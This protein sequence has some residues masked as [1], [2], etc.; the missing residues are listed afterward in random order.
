MNKAANLFILEVNLDEFSIGV[1]NKQPLSTV[2]P[3]QSAHSGVTG[4][5]DYISLNFCL[6]VTDVREQHSDSVPIRAAIG[7]SL[8]TRINLH[9]GHRIFTLLLNE[10]K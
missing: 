1:A 10:N 9:H 6:G 2:I 5:V 3:L 8:Y 7:Q 4:F